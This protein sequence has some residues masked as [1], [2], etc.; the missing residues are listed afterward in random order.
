M[1]NRIQAIFQDA[2]DLQADALEMLA[3][4]RMCRARLMRR[5]YTHQVHTGDGFGITRDGQTPSPR[6]QTFRTG[7]G[8]FAYNLSAN[9]AQVQ[10]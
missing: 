5:Y 4:V 9:L 7:D 2:R 6:P 10:G 1:T 8:W 3:Q